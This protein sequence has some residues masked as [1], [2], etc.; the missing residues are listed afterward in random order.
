MKQTIIR[1]IACLTALLIVCMSIPL[2]AMADG[3]VATG[4]VYTSDP[5]GKVY[6]RATPAVSGTALGQYYNGTVA[7]ILYQ[8]TNGWSQVRIGS[9]VGYMKTSNVPTGIPADIVDNAP[10]YVSTSS[11]WE[12]RQEPTYQSEYAMYGYDVEFR[13]M[14]INGNWWHIELNAEDTA[15]LNVRTTGFIPANARGFQLVNGDYTSGYATAVVKNPHSGDRLNLREE[16]TS[17]SRSLGK[18]YNGTVVALLGDNYNGWYHVSVAG[19]EGWM[20]GT[21]LDVSAAQSNVKDVRPK[22]TVLRNG[23][24]LYSEPEENSALL[25][26]EMLAGTKVTILGQNSTWYHLLC[27][28]T[29]EYGFAR[30]DKISAGDVVTF[31]T[32]TTTV[33][34]PAWQSKKAG[35]LPTAAWPFNYDLNYDGLYDYTIAHVNNPNPDDRLNLRTEP[36]SDG[37]SLGK[38]YNG[39]QAIV[40]EMKEDGWVRVR[41]GDVEGWMDSRFLVVSNN[42]AAAPASC[43]AVLTVRNPNPVGNLNL[44]AGTSTSTP[45]L[46]VYPNG[47]QVIVMGFNH[48]WAHVIVDGKT[49]YM[50]AHYLQD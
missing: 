22:L 43:L 36:K 25:I 24:C 40:L 47:T 23:T 15:Y 12:L 11:A 35:Q 9:L 48:S 44:R 29:G 38:Y 30:V 6:L 27:E 18:Y 37:D 20:S 16:P 21:Y 19:L 8:T 26:H 33:V 2:T 28:E 5:S 45:S 7:E 49:G 32:E 17:S 39:T 4:V 42:P 46:G 31:E 41:I 14:G 10:R 1:L 34:R 3:A 50:V 13:L